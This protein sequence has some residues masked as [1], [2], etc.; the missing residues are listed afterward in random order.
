MVFSLNLALL[1]HTFVHV[2]AL[3][4]Q[5]VIFS[6]LQNP[7]LVPFLWTRLRALKLASKLKFFQND[8]LFQ[9]C[10]KELLIKQN[11]LPLKLKFSDPVK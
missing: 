2:W 7:S 5:S 8:F 3:Y 10:T 11:D 1:S 9:E 4:S 6:E